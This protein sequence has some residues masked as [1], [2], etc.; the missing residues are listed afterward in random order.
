M[1][2]LKIIAVVIGAMLV[3]IVGAAV[4]AP[5]VVDPNDYKPRLAQLAKEHTGRDLSVE[6]D[7]ELSVFPW[8]GF[9]VQRMSLANSA[10]ST[11]PN[12]AEL[13]SM[14][15]RVKLA[16]LLSRELEMDTVEIDGLRLNLAR[17][18]S[19][20]GNWQDFAESPTTAASPKAD[21]PAQ[22]DDGEPKPTDSPE[23]AK[24][25]PPPIALLGLGGIDIKNATIAWDDE[26]SGQKV[27][28][29]NLHLTTGQVVEGK[30][31]KVDISMDVD[32]QTGGLSGTLNARTSLT[33]ARPFKTVT[34]TELSFDAA[35]AGR[36]PDGSTGASPVKVSGKAA[37][38]E[39]DTAAQ[40]LSVEDLALTTADAAIGDV[41][42]NLSIRTSV[43]LDG[44]AQLVALSGLQVD[45]DLSGGPIPAEVL[46]FSLQG[47]GQVN[48]GNGEIGLDELSLSVPQVSLEAVAGKIEVRASGEGNIQAQQYRLDV[49]ELN[50][51]LS[52]TKLPGGQLVI[53]SSSQLAADLAAQ[54]LDISQLVLDTPDLKG[55]GAVQ[56]SQ[57]LTAPEATGRIE[58]ANFNPRVIAALGGQE[59]PVTTDPEALSKASLKTEFAASERRLDLRELA[60]VLD[61]STV[62]GSASMPDLNTQAMVFD[63]TVDKLDADR[64]RPPPVPAGKTK[65]APAAATASSAPKDAAK[66]S[67]AATP[68]ATQ[69]AIGATALPIDTL[70][71]LDL[72][73][74]IRIGRLRTT[75]LALSKV[76][77][78]IRAKQGQIELRPLTARLYGGTYAGAMKFDASGKTASLSVDEKLTRIK[79]D[80]L[81]AALQID[82]GFKLDGGRSSLTLKATATGKT[83]KQVFNFKQVALNANLASKAFPKGRLKFGLGADVKLDVKGETLKA[84]KLNIGFGGAKVLGTLAV[85]QLLSSPGYLANLTMPKFNPRKMLAALGQPPLATADKKALS[86]AELKVKAKGDLQRVALDAV[87]LKL[88]QSRLTGKLAVANFASP[89]IQ[90]DLDLDRINADRYLPPPQGVN[91]K[92]RKKKRKGKSNNQKANREPAAASPG[93][94]SVLLPR[95]FLRALNLD[96][97]LKVG[98]LEINKLKLT[99]VV[100]KAKAKNGKVSLNPLNANLYRGNYAG[101]VRID[102]TGKQPKVVF[103]EKLTNVQAGPLLRAL[104]GEAP[105]SGKTFFTAKGSA[106]GPD[107]LSLRKT[108]NGNAT[109]R[110][111]DGKIHGVDLARLLC[112]GLGS[113]LGGGDVDAGAL[114]GSLLNQAVGKQSNRSQAGDPEGGTRFAELN[115]TMKIKQGVATNNDLR[116]RSPLLRVSGKGRANLVKER[117]NYTVY[118]SVVDSCEG[119]GAKDK[120]LKG[121][122]IPVKVSGK[123]SNLKYEPQWTE[124][125]GALDSQPQ[126]SRANKNKKK[127][128]KKKRRKK[129]EE[130]VEDAL[131]GLLNN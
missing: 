94:A 21:G 42:A 44:L 14:Q 106:T 35:V 48:L 69:A 4:I 113:I 62:T 66:T 121:L 131:K 77:V 25:G 129:T 5:L 63:L 105:L 90:F 120:R 53:K 79:A 87:D 29:R 118:A 108:L 110:F 52:G 111:E 64:Y 11:P 117:I 20:R 84:T 59:L 112:G 54:V 126:K 45:G 115:G 26:V 122:E 56:I 102:A 46:P 28:V 33:G 71:A 95:E 31:V 75:N 9:K 8:L 36:A 97:E 50:A 109:F 70:R 92:P 73:G 27:T 74:R 16:P 80:R 128:N 107:E 82:P 49:S 51:T 78:G 76:D 13:E 55:T 41:K 85:S 68:V 1:K 6:G 124:L 119:Q 72:D 3:V 7:I 104:S 130:Q 103:D 93:S 39:F 57:L 22:P 88:D 114:L 15:L 12:F 18:Q 89:A 91:K 116:M 23:A 96:G 43:V 86:S 30:P 19:G 125:A 47:A 40:R 98:R 99:K 2:A 58:L 60:L 17:D 100:F 34:A 67:N 127:K 10:G 32:D 65:P 83:A 38:G 61:D 81:L 123:F 37:R 24:D 101:K